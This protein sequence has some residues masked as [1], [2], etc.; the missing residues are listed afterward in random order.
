M[1]ILKIYEKYK[2]L[3]ALQQHMFRVASVA[4][5][6]AEH[7]VIDVDID[8]ITKAALLHDMGNILKFNLSQIF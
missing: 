8:C 7:M 4:K 5:M 6:I 1:Q 2:I 3:P